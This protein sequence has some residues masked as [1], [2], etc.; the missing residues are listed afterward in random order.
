MS[1][2]DKPEEGLLSAIRYFAD[3]VN[4]GNDCE[5]WYTYTK[6]EHFLNLKQKKPEKE[7]DTEENP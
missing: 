6:G 7:S 2:Y 4:S 3:E 5:A 1:F